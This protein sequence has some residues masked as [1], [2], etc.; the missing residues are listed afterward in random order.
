MVCS[1]ASGTHALPLLVI[2]KSKKPRCFKN[3]ACLP[4]TYRGQK[5]A[6]MDSEIFMEWFSKMFIPEVK[7]HREKEGKTG[8]VLLL[9][10]NAPTHP[11]LDRLNSVDENFVVMFFP[12]NVTALLQPMDQGIIV[13]CKKLYR[14]QVLQR[15]LI[16]E[17]D[18]D[19]VITFSKQLNLKDC[20]HMLADS[21]DS[22][23]KENLKNGW[24]KL[25]KI[26]DDK[27]IESVQGENMTDIAAICQNIPGFEECD[28]QD[29]NEWLESDHNLQGHQIYEDD[30]IVDVVSNMADDNAE[31]S[32]D[33]DHDNDDP[34]P[35]HSDAFNSLETAMKWFEN[36]PESNSA[37]L[38]VLKR[39]RDLAAKK[40]AAI[41]VQKKISDYFHVTN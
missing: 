28:E 24:N 16:A 41:A 22:L 8:K 11:G 12:P 10:D 35:S 15:L 14:K 26:Q 1:N 27:Q 31:D 37:E 20:C 3:I 33:D 6:W 17:R 40:R 34:K 29:V 32:S 38:L 2:G 18:E 36:Q 23:T 5:S 21:W 19:S 9:I 4:V 39:I 30:E 25:W 13:K 7:K